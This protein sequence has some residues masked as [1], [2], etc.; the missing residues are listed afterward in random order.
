[1]SASWLTSLASLPTYRVLPMSRQVMTLAPLLSKPKVGEK[2]FL[3]LAISTEVVSSML[4]CIGEDG[5]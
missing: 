5:T 4:I 2:L 3:Y 1:M